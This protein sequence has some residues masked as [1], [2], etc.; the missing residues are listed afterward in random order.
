M[1]PANPKNYPGGAASVDLGL[2]AGLGA[3]Q[4]SLDD[5]DEKKKKLLQQQRERMGLSGTSVYGA[6][7]MSLFG[8]AGG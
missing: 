4:T 5:E 2:N 6:A 3:D 1:P 7:S 8:D